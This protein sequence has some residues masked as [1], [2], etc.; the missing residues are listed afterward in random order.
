MFAMSEANHIYEW[1]LHTPNDITTAR[2]IHDRDLGSFGYTL[3]GLAFSNDGSKLFFANKSSGTSEDVV[4]LN[5]SVAFSTF[6]DE[7]SHSGD[8]INSD[9]DETL[10]TGGN[11][12]VASIRTGAIEGSGNP[13]TLGAPL[14]GTYGS[15]TMHAN[16]RYTYQADNEISNWDAGKVGYDQFNYTI[17]QGDPANGADHAVLTI[18]VVGQDDAPT[19]SQAAVDPNFNEDVDASGQD[20]CHGDAKWCHPLT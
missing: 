8:V 4:T 5:T 19:V 14:V 11:L 6:Y 7:P 10:D 3:R 2:F 9:R 16:G 1:I 15:L 17:N 18:K 20:I 12:D 13:G